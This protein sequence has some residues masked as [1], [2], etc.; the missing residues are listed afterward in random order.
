[1]PI[2]PEDFGAV[3]A[4]TA[5][6]EDFG[7]VPI[8]QIS[9][10]EEGGM[11]TSSSASPPA[12][13]G[14]PQE[15]HPTMGGLG[16]QIENIP[17]RAGES[18]K[19]TSEGKAG[20]LT[21]LYGPGNVFQGKDGVYVRNP[22]TGNIELFNPPGFD[23]G[24]IAGLAGPAINVVPNLAA[25]AV[26]GGQ[27]PMGQAL[28]TGGGNLLRR[29]ASALL[30]GEE[31]QTRP[32]GLD[33]P[34][35]AATAVDV[36]GDVATAY[37]IGKGF[38]KA[39]QLFF[40]YGTPSGTLAREGELTRLKDTP[41]ARGGAVL[42]RET[43]VPLRLSQKYGSA[44][45][46]HREGEAAAY[47]PQLALDKLRENARLYS[48]RLNGA[49]KD[50]DSA[51]LSR[52]Q[53]AA[54]V[55]QAFKGELL[56]TQTVISS[57]YGKALEESNRITS[58]RAVIDPTPAIHRIDNE[59]EQLSSTVMSADTAEAVTRL[60]ALRDQLTKDLR[61]TG[62]LKVNEVDD[63]IK[64]Q[65]SRIRDVSDAAEKRIHQVMKSALDDV[66]NFAE[67]NSR[68]GKAA[69][70]LK[71]ARSDYQLGREY[72]RELAATTLGK[73]FTT[74]KGRVAPDKV[75]P[76]SDVILNRIH[77]MTPSEVQYT[78]PIIEKWDRAAAQAVKADYLKRILTSARP[79]ESN[80]SGQVPVVDFK[81]LANQWKLD[82]NFF[83]RFQDSGERN[84]LI[85][86]RKVLGRLAEEDISKKGQGF[87]GQTE[88]GISAVAGGNRVF[89]VKAIL[90]RA[91]PTVMA[92]LLLK[93]EGQR[94]V[95][96]ALSRTISPVK[97]VAAAN[98]IKQ[99][100]DAEMATEQSSAQ[101][102]DLAP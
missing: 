34:A 49:I 26:P 63:L 42:E 6:P 71:A 9:P 38:Q 58:G 91:T 73:M 84:Q 46:Y 55:H 54:R 51:N 98:F 13:L 96:T 21:E 102:P 101:L 18:I 20:F 83:S 86:L 37:G 19:R 97:A 88:Q 28:A 87:V 93:P 94:A 24:D 66:L 59:I 89:I 82:R 30:P 1:M 39:G 100:V 52:A 16:S 67:G 15:V 72:E 79:D 74:P 2:R 81:K 36:G 43:G 99:Y 35:P 62:M 40:G 57:R 4:E 44:E 68:Y 95:E 8:R 11:F 69:T 17:G 56:R 90:R 27:T 22:K 5:R 31:G 78:M 70:I 10:T 47:S 65:S 85:R 77:A 64:S 41:Y 61:E 45:L 60:T 3:R 23:V 92:N 50:I 7:G 53:T 32:F 76:T 29:G 14:W 75:P 12:R 25:M 33:L 48:D 80:F